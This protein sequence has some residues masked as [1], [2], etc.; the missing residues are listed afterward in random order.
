MKA[1]DF[2]TNTA[3]SAKAIFKM[4][5]LSRP[6][7]LKAET[8]KKPLVILANGPS[9]RNTLDEDRRK[10]A[11]TDLLAVNFAAN[12]PVFSELK[13]EYYVLVDPAFFADNPPENIARLMANIASADWLMTLIVPRERVEWMRTRMAA[14]SKI[15]VRGINVTGIEGFPALEHWVFRQRLAMPRPRNVLIPS[16]MAA[17]WLGYRRI[18]LVGA[19]HSWMQSIWV[20]DD[21]NVVSVQPHFYADDEKERQRVTS[22]YRGYHLHDIVHSFYVAFRSYHSIASFAR[23]EGVEIVNSTPGSYIDAFPRRPLLE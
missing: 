18:Y 15:S 3:L 20:D 14:N 19:D 12:T 17:I 1:S 13:P 16:I 4:A 2:V 8:R 5:V 7:S 11:Q 6:S 9:L 21:N 23:A 22:E 10:L